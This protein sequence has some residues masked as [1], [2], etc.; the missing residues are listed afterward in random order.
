MPTQ[1]A[2]SREPETKVPSEPIKA[3]ARR[4]VLPSKSAADRFACAAMARAF[5]R[6][7]EMSVLQAEALALAVAELASNIARH[8][9]EGTIELR[10]LDAPRP[11]VEV[12]CRDRGPGIADVASA[13]RDGVSGGCPLL[14]DIDGIPAGLGLGLGAI[15]RLVDEVSIESTLGIG[16]TVTLRKWIR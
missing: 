7:A 2:S 12:V 13:R 14:R 15:E 8:A 4:V 10:H 16:T 9:V 5:G 3:G 1:P 6:S 11:H